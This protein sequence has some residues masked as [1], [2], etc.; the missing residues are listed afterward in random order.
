M[1]QLTPQRTPQLCLSAGSWTTSAFG[2]AT[3][4]LPGE[5]H[6]LGRHLS[7]CHQGHNK[8]F[9]VKGL[10]DTLHA[11]TAPRVMTTLLLAALL[12][13]SSALIW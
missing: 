1:P 5:L 10:A 13:A 12:F 7:S 8:M 11:F 4:T 9:W 3:D 6:A 2:N